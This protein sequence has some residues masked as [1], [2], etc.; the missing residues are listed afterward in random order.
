MW[1]NPKTGKGWTDQ[2]EAVFAQIMACWLER[3]PAIRLYRRCGT[4]LGKA[5]RYAKELGVRKERV[6]AKFKGQLQG[7]KR[8]LASARK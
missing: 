7:Q 3:L 4:D 1:M 2:E 6:R 8:A 5:V